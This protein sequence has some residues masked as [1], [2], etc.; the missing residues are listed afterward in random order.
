[1]GN[2]TWKSTSECEQECRL[3]RTGS[4]WT[5]LG[6]G[7]VLKRCCR[8]AGLGTGGRSFTWEGIVLVLMMLGHMTQNIRLSRFKHFFPQKVF[9][10]SLDCL[11]TYRNL[12]AKCWNKRHALSA[13]VGSNFLFLQ[14]CIFLHC[15][16]II[17][18]HYTDACSLLIPISPLLQQG[19]WWP[20]L[21]LNL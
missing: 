5:V 10:Y 7:A 1:M 18:K 8:P 16:V 2:I 9:L 3:W 17:P 6:G 19:Q 13:L 20:F 14:C 21:L 4:P 11:Q 12:P 15:S